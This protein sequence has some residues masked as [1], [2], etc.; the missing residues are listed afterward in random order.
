MTE[1]R[2]SGASQGPLGP[3]EGSDP[4]ANS[5][6]ERR[7]SGASQG[8]LGPEEGSDLLGVEDRAVLAA[9]FVTALGDEPES[10]VTPL[11][12]RAEAG[13]RSRR[14]R[15]KVGALLAAA[16]VAAVGVIG[17]IRLVDRPSGAQNTNAAVATVPAAGSVEAYSQPQVPAA[18]QPKGAVTM[19][20]AGTA[21]LPMTAAPA[22]SAGSLAADNQGGGAAA[23]GAESR[24]EQTV[25]PPLPDQVVGAVL[26]QLP[27]GTLVS[28]FAAPGADCG[29]RLLGTQVF[30]VPSQQLTVTVFLLT[31]DPRCPPEN[32]AI[33]GAAG[34][35]SARDDHYE[36]EVTA[37]GAAGAT[38]SGLTSRIAKAALAAAR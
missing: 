32:C 9:M 12:V 8:P 2:E 7:E 28:P 16:A 34:G 11:R 36:V 17:G 18:D 21:G 5:V 30:S 15:V 37:L 20:G 14:R 6:A 13:R 23:A 29:A 31:A 3:E 24:T 1:R 27:A 33:S 35:G 26:A 38:P 22:A 25:C 10:A 4:G 19:S